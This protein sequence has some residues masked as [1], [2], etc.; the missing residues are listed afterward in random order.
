MRERLLALFQRRK[1]IVRDDGILGEVRPRRQYTAGI[2]RE[3]ACMGPD[4]E[5]RRWGG[6]TR[7]VLLLMKSG[8]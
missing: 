1:A 6:G 2:E 8:G 7:A 4:S 3:A 5:V